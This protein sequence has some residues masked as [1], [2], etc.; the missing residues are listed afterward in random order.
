MKLL[1]IDPNISLSSPSMNGVVRALPAL[2]RAGFQIEAWCWDCDEGIGVDRIVRLPRIGAVRV[3]YGHA[4]GAWARLRSWWHFRVRK[5]PRPDV[6]YTVA[7]YLP[8]CDVCHVHFSPWDWE[9]RQRQLGVRSLRDRLERASNRAGLRTADRFLRRTTAQRVLCVS[10][11][12]ADDIRT[13]WPAAANRLHVLPNSYD[14][15]RFN[16]GVREQ[17]RSAM[18]TGLGFA[19]ADKVFIFVSTGHYRR[20]GFFLAAESV[21]LLRK[22]HPEAKLLVV[23]GTRERLRALQAELETVVSDWRGFITF[24]GTVTDPEKYFAAA[25]ALLF[26]SYS[27]AFALVEVEADACGLPLFLTRHHGSE[28]I[29]EDG[30]NGRFVEFAPEQIESVLAK[31]V[32]GAWKPRRSTLNRALDARTY[33]EKLVAELLAAA[34]A[35]FTPSALP[36]QDGGRKPAPCPTHVMP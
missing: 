25:D 28:M 12:V 23:G 30:V 36:H 16:P 21:A 24:T 7:W 4:F 18:R 5:Q 32:T 15:A 26:P 34:A 3:L 1:I 29:L 33:S 13:V 14:P 27:E 31:F 22:R 6:I 19:A 10:D 2:R 8:R 17:W 35:P 11:A 20:K 9:R